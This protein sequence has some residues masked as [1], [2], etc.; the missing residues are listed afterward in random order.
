[1][2]PKAVA[3]LIELAPH[4]T[5]LIPVAD[6]FF[7][8]RSETDETHRRAMEAMAEGLRSDIGQ[9][10]AAHESLYRQLNDQSEKLAGITAEIRAAK[11]A[12]KDAEERVV[13]LEK[14][15][16]INT[17]V[18]IGVLAMNVALLV[19]ALYFLLHH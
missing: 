6:R 11:T 10:T 2:W 19:I 17:E 13:R 5:Q 7:R 15:L 3:Q 4:I 18:L 12:V 8:N 16:R 1:M 9:A 14:S